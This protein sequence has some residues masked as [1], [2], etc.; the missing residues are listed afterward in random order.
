MRKDAL[1]YADDFLMPT[2]P[3]HYGDPGPRGQARVCRSWDGLVEWAGEHH[4]CYQHLTDADEEW[5]DHDE[6]E[7]YLNCP[8][9]SPYYQKA[10]EYRK[11]LQNDGRDKGV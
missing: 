3:Q 8:E 4:A 5:R 11:T 10:A 9:D 1:C 7:R 2:P 6:M